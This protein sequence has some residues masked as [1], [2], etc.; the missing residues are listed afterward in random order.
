MSHPLQESFEPTVLC[1]DDAYAPCRLERGRPVREV[2]EEAVWR[3][4]SFRAE[5]DV[6]NLRDDSL[7]TFWQSDSIQ[8]HHVYIQFPR[9]TAIGVIYIYIDYKKDESYTPA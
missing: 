5:H 9:K 4:S 3:V 1:P 8:P 7:E 6:N 2:G